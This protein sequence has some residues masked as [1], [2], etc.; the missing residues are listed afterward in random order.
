MAVDLLAIALAEI[1]SVSDRRLNRLINPLVNGDLHPFLI[2]EA[3]LNSG[4]MIAQYVAAS[5]YR[6]NCHLAQ[7]AVPDNIV[8]SGLQEDH[9]NMGT[10]AALKLLKLAE[11]DN[12]L[13]AIEYLLAAQACDFTKGRKG[14]GT[15]RAHTLLRK[16]FKTW[17]QDRWLAPEIQ[18]AAELLES[19]T[20][21][22]EPPE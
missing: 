5:L 15:I 9:L 19:T 22:I 21:T 13:L 16:R 10:N 12:N 11:N 4:M 8:T 7:S 20:I 2:A 1:G 14:M 18:K 6:E 3:G 17:T